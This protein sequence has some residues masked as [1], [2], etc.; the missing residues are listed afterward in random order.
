MTK[1]DLIWVLIRG[2][3]FGLVVRALFSAK[4]FVSALALSGFGGPEGSD[5]ARAWAQSAHANMADAAMS[6]VFCLIIG[7]YLLRGGN[8][9]YKLINHVGPE[10]SNTTPHADA[11]DVP[12]SANDSGARAGGRER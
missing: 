4:D 10:R 3:G 9:I 11:R 6:A 1:D 8:W 2:A 12:A 7:V 5:F